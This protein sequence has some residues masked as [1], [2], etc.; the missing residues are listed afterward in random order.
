M[1]DFSKASRRR[2]FFLPSGAKFVFLFLPWVFVAYG[3]AVL[4]EYLTFYN[5]SVPATARVVFVEASSDRLGA[6]EA[7]NVLQTAGNWPVPAF[8]YQHENGMFYI[9]DGI[10]D[11]RGW[12][13]HHGEFVD[14]RYNRVSPAHA[15]PVTLFKF[16]WTPGIFIVGGF[17]AFLSML[18]AFIKAENPHARLFPRIL[19]SKGSLK[20]RRK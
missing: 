17:L 13:Y 16:W 2:K 3:L 14:I 18:I 1:L 5:N 7:L 11:G 8:L 6:T 20:L 12:R 9:G 4:Q 10:V 15:Q 19:Q